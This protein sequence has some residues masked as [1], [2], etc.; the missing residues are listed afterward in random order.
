MSDR[1]SEQIA[2]M[3]QEARELKNENQQ[4]RNKLAMMFSQMALK[5]L[6]TG[7][8]GASYYRAQWQSVLYESKLGRAQVKPTVLTPAIHFPTVHRS[9]MASAASSMIMNQSIPTNELKTSSSRQPVNQSVMARPVTQEDE[10]ELDH[11][12]V[13]RFLNEIRDIEVLN[14][15]SRDFNNFMAQKQLFTYEQS[16][17]V[18]QDES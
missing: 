6:N 15:R 16:Q 10:P 2:R 13:T 7:K 9:A 14:Q 12:F 1:L 17:T 5:T 3:K 8:D 11:D 4:E 18:S